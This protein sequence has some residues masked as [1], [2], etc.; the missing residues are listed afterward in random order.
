MTSEFL[1]SIAVF[2]VGAF[3]GGCIGWFIRSVIAD[4]QREDEEIDRRVRSQELVDR[5]VVG[6]TWP[7]HPARLAF[8]ENSPE[9]PLASS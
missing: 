8:R 2:V 6:V 9:R 1:L 4:V 7:P 3:L 5:G